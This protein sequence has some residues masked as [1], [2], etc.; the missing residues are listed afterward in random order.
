MG[1]GIVQSVLI[2]EILSGV[3]EFKPLSPLAFNGKHE[4]MAFL[5]QLCKFSFQCLYLFVCNESVLF[6]GDESACQFI[7]FLF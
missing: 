7:V 1:L 3:H 2:L 6:G 4:F 5:D